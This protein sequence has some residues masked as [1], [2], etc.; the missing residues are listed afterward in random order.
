MRNY[1]TLLITFLFIPL[2]LVGQVTQEWVVRY[3]SLPNAYPDSFILDR[4]GNI[5]AIACYSNLVCLKYDKKGHLI[6]SKNLNAS[7]DQFSKSIAIDDSNNVYLV[8][9][10]SGHILIYKLNSKGKLVWAKE[11]SPPGY[12][13]Y[14]SSI[15]HANSGNIY[16]CG[17]CDSAFVIKVDRNGSYIGQMTFGSNIV[18]LNGTT[19]DEDENI[20]FTGSE[21][22]LS[23]YEDYFTAKIDSAR[24][25]KWF[26]RF[27]TPMY[28]EA[29]AVS[30]D[31]FG[32]VFVT[33]YSGGSPMA[34][35]LRNYCTIK[36]NSVGDSIWVRR[37]NG[38]G[39]A[40]DIPMACVTDDSGNVYV[41]GYSGGNYHDYA[42]VKYSSNGNE[43]WVSR[44]DGF[45]LD[46][47]AYSMTLDK[48]NNVYVTG[49]SFNLQGN[50]D[51]VTVRYSSDGVQQWIM[52][53]NSE[54]DSTDYGD[55]VLA[56]SSLNVYALGW[57][58][59]P[60]LSYDILL[61]KYTQPTGIKPIS[62]SMPVAFNLSQNYP[63]PFNPTTKIKFDIASNVKS[64]QVGTG[65]QTSNVKL[66]IYDILGRDIATLVNEQVKPGSYEVEWDASNYSSGVYI[67]KLQT[68]AFSESKKMVLVK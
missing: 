11:F 65:S 13:N 41:T 42:T 49:N 29:T 43:V 66:V 26:R 28:D 68:E 61:I 54:Y 35:W 48:Y 8:G 31:K 34:Y 6:W 33:G 21:Y 22:F 30:V 57:S 14:L 4:V 27:V 55:F 7:A 63:N 46:D 62:N 64:R 17:L 38:T 12:L 67:Y 44:Y 23:T 39:N 16:V 58:W 5:Y 60:S 10:Y 47:Y 15:F 20:Y 59:S 18:V 36:Y 3:S 45:A 52:R 56:D 50:R 2:L 25:M 32:N 37:Y 1:F 9:N 24:N 51:I 53:Y 40:E 19:I